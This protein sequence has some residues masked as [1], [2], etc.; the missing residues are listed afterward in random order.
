[1]ENKN[2]IELISVDK[3]IDNIDKSHKFFDSDIYH[4]IENGIKKYGQLKN[5]IINKKFEIIDGKYIFKILKELGYK[6]VWCLVIEKDEEYFEF[7]LDNNFKWDYIKV[8]KKI[9]KILEQNLLHEF[10]VLT[11]MH[12]DE[13][14]NFSRILDYDF[15]NK[16]IEKL[17]LEYN[18][19]KEESFF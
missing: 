15:L 12:E 3:I 6:N 10:K 9:K 16:D 4:K 2:N 7:I 13:I 5:I 17:Y 18:S 8:A 11:M 1:M 14:N 19:K